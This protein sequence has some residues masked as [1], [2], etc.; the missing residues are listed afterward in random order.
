MDVA[1][2]GD[3]LPIPLFDREPARLIHTLRT[4]HDRLRQAV[5]V[6]GETYGG[7]VAGV[8][9]AMLEAGAAS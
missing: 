8:R 9:Q 1:I 2:V 7:P 5:A 6:I 3:T 4:P